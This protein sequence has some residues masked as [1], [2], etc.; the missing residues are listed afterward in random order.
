MRIAQGR[1]RE[2]LELAERAE[3][4][5]GPHDRQMLVDAH[6]VRA[7]AHAKLG[8]LEDARAAAAVAVAVAA[9]TDSI[10][11]R[12]AAHGALAETLLTAGELTRALAAAKQA[13]RLLARLQ[14]PSSRE[15]AADLVERIDRELAAAEAP[16]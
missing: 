8:E 7:R 10:A 6:A 11:S 5:G 16:A 12:A 3:E 2:A 1:F 13:E 4:T 14:R 15:A 9:R